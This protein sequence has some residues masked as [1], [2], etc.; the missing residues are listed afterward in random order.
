[1]KK[2]MSS[3]GSMLLMSSLIL[4]GCGGSTS[5]TSQP[6][7]QPAEQPKQ[8]APKQEQVVLSMHSWR[9]EDTDGYKKVIA[10]FEEE[11][12]GI[13]IEFKPFKA[14]EYNTILNTALQSDSGPDIM[15]LRPYQAG[16]SL[17]DAGYLEPVDGIAGI[18]EFAPDVMAAAT[19]KD[20][21]VYGV[22]LSLNSTQVYYN[23]KI[24]EENGLTEPKTW[25][26]LIT[27]AKTLKDKGVT[28]FAFGSKEGWLLSL[29]HGVI[30]PGTY[31]AKE[32]VDPLLKGEKDFKSAE[33]AKSIE[34]LKELSAYFPDNYTGL[35]G[36]DIRTL[37]FTG[38]AAMYIHGSFEL[39]V[40]QK[41]NPDL[42]LDFFPMP[43]ENGEAV[44]TTW[45]DG[46]Y[47]VNA[48]S[49]HKAEAMKFMEFMTTKKFGEVFANEFKRIPAL[50]GVT[51]DEPLV[52]KMAE[53]SQKSSSPYLMVVNFNQGDPTTKA[54]IENSL[55]G[56]FLDQLTP[57][58]VVDAVQKSAETWFEPFKK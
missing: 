40:L 36:N 49:P 58:Q 43:M 14:T 39:E 17:A 42:A 53:W 56:M 2:L 9:V 57:E 48:K 22:P 10:A 34:R 7:Q 24:F 4:S 16:M 29:T 50:P 11:N 6:N 28:P 37:F 8:E 15:Q 30:A 44:I 54:T 5:E 41:M 46:S 27:T 35:D 33:F 20:G 12:P 19:A 38:K 32:F 21:K 1:M 18:K 52:N 3:I 23:K 51:V 13:K 26:E 45:V 31:N 55:Q 25:D 47:G